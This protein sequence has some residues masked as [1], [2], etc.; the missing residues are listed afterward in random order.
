MS[1][2]FLHRLLSC[3]SLLAVLAAV[4]A[5]AQTAGAPNTLDDRFR[6]Q[7]YHLSPE[8]KLSDALMSGQDDLIL[9]RHT[10]LITVHAG[11]TRN[12]T[13]NAPLSPDEPKQDDYGV[14]DAGIEAGTVIAGHVRVYANA[15][16]VSTQYAQYEALNY[17]AVTAAVGAQ[18]H[19]AGIDLD[20]AWSP[21]AVYGSQNFHHLSLRQARY[22]AQLS[23]TLKLGPVYLQ[24][25]IHYDRT[26]AHPADYDNS[27][28][29]GRL[30]LVAPLKLRR[31]VTIY[32]S[33]GFEQRFYDHYFSDLLGVDRKDKLR[34][35][36]IGAR[37]QVTPALEISAQVSYQKNRSTSD[38]SVYKARGGMVGVT[39][40]RKF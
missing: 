17:S 20:V 23:T 1:T 11:Y 22:S 7:V 3:A 27:A 25:S 34:D 18:A 30:S 36:A 35:V 8:Q 40:S 2:R 12:V 33:G 4:P 29:G 28:S 32:L 16:V 15:G 38:V 13:S 9:L 14:A 24:P 31:P 6:N 19:Y 5:H 26:R 10:K 39:L 21:S 37:W